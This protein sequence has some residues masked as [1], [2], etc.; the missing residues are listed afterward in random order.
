MLEGSTPE[1]YVG[2]MRYLRDKAAERAKD[3][4]LSQMASYMVDD[5]ARDVRL[6]HEFG[7]FR[8][9]QLLTN[10]SYLSYFGS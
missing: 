2:C 6:H 8:V 1:K 9:D 4:R 5:S 3:L 7:S 10:L